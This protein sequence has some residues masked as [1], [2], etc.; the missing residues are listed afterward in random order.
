[1]I[2]EEIEEVCRNCTYYK[3][4]YANYAH[5]ACRYNPPLP[6]DDKNYVTEGFPETLSTN[7]CGKFKPS[8]ESISNVLSRSEERN[9]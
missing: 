2:I 8:N 7:W 3:V 9:K 1:M 6:R 5:T 4:F